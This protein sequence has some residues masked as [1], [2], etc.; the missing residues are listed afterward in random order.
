MAILGA[1][2]DGVYGDWQI[3]GLKSIMD[4]I[5]SIGL[6]AG[7]GPGVFLSAASVLLY[8]GGISLVARWAVAPGVGT[9]L[10]PSPALTEFNAVG[11][12]VLLALSLKLLGVRDLKVGNLLPALGL[13]PLLGWALARLG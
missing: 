10:A 1:I 9:A 8:Q 3:L 7:L 2:R 11:G 12:T 6:V 13:A 4:G 5:S